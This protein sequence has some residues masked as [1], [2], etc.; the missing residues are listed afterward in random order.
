MSSRSPSATS[1]EHFAGGGIVGGKGLAGSGLHPLAV[2]EH[3]VSLG[4]KTAKHS[5]RVSLRML[6]LPC[7]PPSRCDFYAQSWLESSN[8]RVL[9]VASSML[10]RPRGPRCP[11]G[12]TSRSPSYSREREFKRANSMSSNACTS[13]HGWQSCCGDFDR[14][15]GVSDRRCIHHISGDAARTAS[16][17]D[18]DRIFLGSGRDPDALGGGFAEVD[19]ATC[20]CRPR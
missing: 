10:P 14:A 4:D 15:R 11:S 20:D 2:D 12:R 13:W 1:R 3:L 17:Y 5:D 19:A 18:R 6:L 9:R 8:A 16:S 7:R